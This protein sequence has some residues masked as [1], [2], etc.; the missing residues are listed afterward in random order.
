M[1]TYG[2]TKLQL[3][4]RF[5][6]Q[7]LE[8]ANLR[9][10]LDTMRTEQ[11]TQFTRIAQMQAELDLLPHAR[12]RRLSLSASLPVPPNGNGRAHLPRT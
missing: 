12:R 2:M 8:L 1:F 4:A 6:A 11:I 9:V 7:A 3:E 5:Q 10:A